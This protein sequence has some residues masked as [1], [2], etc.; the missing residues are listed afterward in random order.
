MIS[1][2]EA[3]ALIPIDRAVHA[4]THTCTHTD[5]DESSAAADVLQVSAGSVDL[6][7]Q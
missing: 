1:V 4:C 7:I 2:S 3:F 6:V 5:D